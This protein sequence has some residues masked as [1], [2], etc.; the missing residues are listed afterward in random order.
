MKYFLYRGVMPVLSVCL[1]L[2]VSACTDNPVGEGDHHDDHAEVNGLELVSGTT[3]V[4]RVLDGQVSCDAPP[5]GI[6]LRLGEPSSTFE[7]HFLDDEGNEVHA[8]DLDAAFSLSFLVAAPEVASL[9]KLGDWSIKATAA[10]VGATRI[11]LNLDHEG[12][13]DFT[14]PPLANSDA[15]SITVVAP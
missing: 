8:E 11:Q 12:H 3:V 13:P 9:E 14:T 10:S 2:F 6:T 4:F 7:V 15:I 5:C 1:F